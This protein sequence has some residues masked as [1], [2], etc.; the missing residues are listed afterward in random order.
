MKRGKRGEKREG[1]KERGEDFFLFHQH[2]LSYFLY[3]QFIQQPLTFVRWATMKR[4][5]RGE[6]REERKERGEKRGERTFS[7]FISILYP[8]SSILYPMHPP[9]CVDFCLP[10][11]LNTKMFYIDN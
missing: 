1:R 11:N 4:G 6:E 7:S 2:P 8:I 9:M 5:K 3:P 10:Y